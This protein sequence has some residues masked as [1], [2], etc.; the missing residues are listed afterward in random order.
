MQPLGC[1]NEQVGLETEA[2]KMGKSILPI[3]IVALLATIICAHEQSIQKKDV[4]NVVIQSFQ[5]SY[6]KAIIK[7]FSKELKE[8]SVLYEIESVEGK[9]H[10]DITYASDGSLISI[11]ESF[12]CKNL[13]KAVQTTISHK[14]PKAKIHICEKVTKSSTIQF[15]ILLRQESGKVEVLLNPDGTIVKIEKK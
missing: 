4:P 13:P 11:E 3:C 12:P 9:I 10:R 14:Y 6:P 2:R 8:G 5:G 7:G 1:S 15:E